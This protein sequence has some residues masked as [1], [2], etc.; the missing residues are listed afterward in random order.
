[1]SRLYDV[2]IFSSSNTQQPTRLYK[3]ARI[4]VDTA[5]LLVMCEK[6]E[7]A[8]ASLYFPRFQWAQKDGIMFDAM[9]PK[10]CDRD[11]SQL[12]IG[13][14]VFCAYAGDQ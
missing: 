4:S 8:N 5:T 11:G 9:E 13:R 3:R 1:M 7:H 12:Y 10:G 2:Q 6:G 14:Q